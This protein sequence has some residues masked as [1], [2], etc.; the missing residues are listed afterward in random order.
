MN[1]LFSDDQAV[2]MLGFGGP[3]SLQEVR[4]FIENVVRGRNIPPAR[5]EAVIEQYKEIG[6][7]SPFNELTYDQAISLEDRLDAEGLSIPVYVAMLYW[8]PDIGET[9]QRMILDGVRRVI[10][11]VMAPHRTEASFNR[12]VQVVSE[13]ANRLAT[14]YGVSLSIEYLPSWNEDPDFIQAIVAQV[15]EV[16]SSTASKSPGQTSIIFTAHS[17]PEQMDRISGYAKQVTGTAQLAAELIQEKFGI[18]DWTVAY[19]SRSGNPK[20]KWL[21]PDLST[22]LARDKKSGKKLA[23]VVPIGFL[24]DH[25]EVLYDLDVL[26][27]KSAREVG[28]EMLRC[29]TVGSHRQFIALLARLVKSKA[30]SL[31]AKPERN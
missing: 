20:E 14:T 16:L 23:V 10:A 13:N 18:K 17:I 4:P 28:I 5:I 21:E 12:Y 25:V 24:C 27:A 6:G 31:Y 26:A 7:K 3:T 15:D 2:L 1:S 11:V 29:H 22:V 30:E 9:L 19:Q 8:S